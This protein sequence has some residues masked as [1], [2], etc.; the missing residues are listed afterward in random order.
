MASV[1]A[2]TAGTTIFVRQ[3]GSFLR[4]HALAIWLAVVPL[5]AVA[6]V[7]RHWEEVGQ[8]GAALR[9]AHPRWIAAGVGIEIATIAASALTYRIILGR[10]GHSLSCLTVAGV[11]LR[12]TA[13][14]ALFFVNGPASVYVLLRILKQRRVPVDD[15]LLTVALRS[16]AGQIAFVAILIAALAIHGANHALIIVGVLLAAS[17]AAAPLARSRWRWRLPWVGR[18]PFGLGGRAMA[19]MARLR[20]HR[21]ASRDLAWPVV[22]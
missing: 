9:Q 10:L 21:L 1:Q 17:I 2:E 3:I 5:L 8:I 18:L 7:V 20:G 15:G 4:Q 14:G 19:F 6:L 12:R 16:V 22:L 13:L 11:H